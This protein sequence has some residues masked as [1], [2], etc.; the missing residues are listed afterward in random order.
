MADQNRLEPQARD[1]S[2]IELR[3]RQTLADRR[4]DVIQGIHLEVLKERY[5]LL[6]NTKEVIV[7]INR[8]NFVL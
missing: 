5:P 2:G 6:F 3:M 1:V 7:F 8:A 4:T